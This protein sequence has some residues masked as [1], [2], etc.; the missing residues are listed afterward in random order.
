MKNLVDIVIP[1]HN[2]IHWLAWCLEDIFKFPSERLQNVYVVNDKSS[3]AESSKLKEIVSQ[4]SN[5]FLVENISTD[6]GFGHACNLGSEQGNSALILFLNTDCLLVGGVLDSLCSVF[7]DDPEVALACPV[8]NNSPSLTY[9]MRSGYSY[10][11]MASLV[12]RVM[13]SDSSNLVTEACTIVGNCLMV[14]RDFYEKVGGFSEEWGVGYGEETD[15]HMK[16][17]SLG[18]KGVVHTGCYVYHFGGGTFNF[19]ENIETHKKKNYELFISKWGEDYR[20]LAKR[21]KDADPID[22]MSRKIDRYFTDVSESINLDVLFYL[23]CIDQGIGGIHAV[24]NVCNDLIR[25]GIKASCAIVGENLDS[26]LNS[27]KE[28]I[29]FSPLFYSSTE[30]FL[31]DRVVIPKIVFSTIF[32]SAPIV[33]KYAKARNAMPIQFVQGYEG[34]FDN[35]AQYPSAC[36]SYLSSKRLVTTSEWLKDKVSRHLKDGQQ[37][38]KLPLIINKEIFFSAESDRK[39]DV[40][41]VLRASADKGQ[42]LLI[43]ILDHLA[44]ESLAITVLYSKAYESLVDKYPEVKWVPLPIDQYSLAKLLRQVKVFVDCSLHEGFGLM[45]LEAALCGCSVVASDSGGIR[46]FANEFDMDLIAHSPD[47]HNHLHSIHKRLSEYANRKSAPISML[48]G[49]Q[50]WIEFITPLTSISIPKLIPKDSTFE[51]FGH[52]LLSPDTVP[53]GYRVMKKAYDFFRP[54]V[55]NRI[56]LILK[57][58]IKGHG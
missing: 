49:G 44:R 58:I 31:A 8:S 23:P 4:Y 13:A 29:L 45:P 3:S 18:Q 1:V 2:S 12:N 42:W 10:L 26:D 53:V 33:A 6:G 39:L 35:G 5:V 25:R 32:F 55:P 19:K 9:A 28:P 52:R 30:E 47:P 7:D 21:C 56:H 16:A 14:R 20:K 22:I 11:D 43:E 51:L 50:S 27:F 41:L 24:I 34:Y 46:D 37:L 15:L 38:T 48:H 36:N 57:V 54:I 17:L 40:C